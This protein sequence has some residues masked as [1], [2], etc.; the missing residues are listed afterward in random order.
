M[1]DKQYE[2]FVNVIGVLSTVVVASTIVERGLAFIFEHEWFV[3]L[4]TK[5]VSDPANS[6]KTVRLS[7]IPGLKGIIA[8]AVSIA[9]SLVYNCDILHVLFVTESSDFFGKL[10]TGFVIAGGSAGAITI[11][12]SYLN[13]SKQSRDAIIKARKAEAESAM[14]IAEL[15]VKEAEANQKKAEANQKKAE[16]E[17]AM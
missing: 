2:L 8:L 5:E 13:F 6:T 14:Q 3:R 1:V 12:Q 11:F 17:S 4:S 7:K 15:A 10:V 16:A 9:I